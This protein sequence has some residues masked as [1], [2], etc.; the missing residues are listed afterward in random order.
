MR[1]LARAFRSD[2]RYQWRYGFYFIYLFLIAGFVALLR[3]LPEGWRQTALSAVL[4]SDPALLGFFFIGGIL[5]LERGEGLLDA[6]FASPLRPWEYLAA[7]AASLGLLS[8]L[9]GC[10]IAL[11]SGV[12]GVAFPLL[13]P[14]LLFGSACFTLIGVSVSVNLRSMNAFLSVDGLWEAVLLVPPLLLLLGV[15]FPPLEAF[16]G[17]AVLR[18]AEA[19]AG[20]GAAAPAALCL[21]G[22]L[23]AA[24][25][26]AD[27]R[28]K[29]ALCRLGGGRA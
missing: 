26:L 23:A 10:L 25:W 18:L 24:F 5:Q 4:L 1:R 21:L 6:L 14:S 7:K 2:I 15:S 3:L 11:G 16:P 8:A 9:A 13:A 27:R 29:S 28:L 12:P 19:S 17:S 22:W 20:R